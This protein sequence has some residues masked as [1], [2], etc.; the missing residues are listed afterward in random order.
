MKTPNMVERC[1]P[2]LEQVFTHF[3]LR[4]SLVV[5][6]FVAGAQNLCGSARD[7]K[8]TVH[9]LLGLFH[10]FIGKLATADSALVHPLTILHPLN[11]KPQRLKMQQNFQLHYGGQE[12]IKEKLLGKSILLGC[13]EPQTMVGSVDFQRYMLA[14]CG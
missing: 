14:E 9:K 10:P 13:S 11:P 1:E 5:T 2:V 3:L 8:R 4:M 6:T 12:N 7:V